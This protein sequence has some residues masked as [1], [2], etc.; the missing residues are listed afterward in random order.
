MSDK[1][2]RI[3]ITCPLCLSN[4]QEEITFKN[5]QPCDEH[6]LTVFCGCAAIFTIDMKMPH[7]DDMPPGVGTL[8]KQ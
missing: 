5:L 7:P 1:T 3:S 8:Y 4:R 6:R 2:A